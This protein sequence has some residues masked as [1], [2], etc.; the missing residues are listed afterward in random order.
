MDNTDNMDTIIKRYK[1]I[2]K[3]K[4]YHGSSKTDM[5][6][7]IDLLTNEKVFFRVFIKKISVSDSEEGEIYLKSTSYSQTLENEIKIYKTIRENLITKPTLNIRNL[8]CIIGD[9]VINREELKKW[10]VNSIGIS[11]ESA[12]QNIK[13]TLLFT[14]AIMSSKDFPRIPITMVS[15]KDTDDSYLKQQLR[16]AQEFGII[17]DK[18]FDSSKNYWIHLN[19]KVEWGYMVSPLIEDKIT[20]G[21]YIQTL[22]TL[23]KKES[24]IE[25]C[26]TIKSILKN[27]YPR[28]SDQVLNNFVDFLQKNQDCIE[29]YYSEHP[30]TEYLLKQPIISFQ[31][32]WSKYKYKRMED[33]LDAFFIVLLTLFM[34][35]S[36]GINHNDI[37]LD[38]VFLNYKYQGPNRLHRT[39]YL[40]IYDKDLLLI[41]STFMPVVFDYD[42]SVVYPNTN[43]ELEKNVGKSGGNCPT[44]N[45]KRDILRAICNFYQLIRNSN[46]P[47]FVELCDEILNEIVT[48]TEIAEEMKNSSSD[49]SHCN[50]SVG[51]SDSALCWDKYIENGVKGRIEILNWFL[52]KTTFKRVKLLD[53]IDVSKNKEASVNFNEV[54]DILDIFYKGLGVNSGMKPIDIKTL[55]FTNIQYIS[56]SKNFLF[57]QENIDQSMQIVELIYSICSG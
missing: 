35:S 33:C 54:K 42:R 32:A 27:I 44:F 50:L 21:E 12:E 7:A 8:S 57:W 56:A 4:T 6:Q 1:I 16:K 25:F 22:V 36:I 9:G 34:L 29:F 49:D 2:Q 37:H 15:E 13:R 43:I 51:D 38:N 30:F 55:I 24:N 10:L 53:L 17:K 48:S 39:P 52:N 45:E 28:E 47:T 19:D 14:S 11:Q 26:N 3:Q 5:W 31:D 23:D 40:L 20:I 46:E 41:D 18:Y